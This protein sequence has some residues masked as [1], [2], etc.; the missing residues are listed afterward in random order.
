MSPTGSDVGRR[1]HGPPSPR[2]SSSRP[3]LAAA[4]SAAAAVAVL[5]AGVSTRGA[6]PAAAQDA[7][8]H[9]PAAEIEDLLRRDDLEV[10]DRRTLR[11]GRR[12]TDL[13]ILDLGEAGQLAAKWQRAPEGGHE[14]NN[15]PRYELAAYELQK[16]F[17]D[18]GDYVVPPTV[19]RCFRP[20]RY[21]ALAG[22]DDPP[23]PTFE[24][25]DC[26]LVVLQYWLR[27]VTSSGVWDEDRMRTDEAYLRHLANLNVLT[28]LIDHKDA[29]TGNLLIS[30]FEADPRV[31]VVD[32][33]I[34]FRA[35]K[36]PRGS[37]WRWLRVD[38]IPEATAE[39][40]RD[41]DRRLLRDRLGVL[42]QFEAGPGG[43]RPAPVSENLD[44]SRGIRV[45]GES[46]QLGLDAQEIDGL[47]GR[48]REL[49]GR[50]DRGELTT[51]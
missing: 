12:R 16:L 22:R 39:R 26:V 36:S 35:R 48:I 4:R 29:N 1:G 46:I 42:L 5:V 34:S 11:S 3:L 23:D 9:R 44:P 37:E 21:A 6:A 49:L 30:T 24:G 8:V 50:L 10:T 32:N 18:P 28:H 17:L 13:V 20:S 31:F 7:N 25:T 15:A 33:G 47:Y 27:N 41:I 43:Y 19:C 51:F 2:R 38:R 14:W 45:E 40:L